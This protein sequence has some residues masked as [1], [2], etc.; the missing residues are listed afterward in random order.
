M[1]SGDEHARV[2]L[3]NW[4]TLSYIKDIS[5]EEEEEQNANSITSLLFTDQ[6]NHNLMVI[7]E[8]GLINI[9]NVNTGVHV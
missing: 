5:L 2:V 3:W 7:K 6:G 9:I 1:V 4:E 8:T